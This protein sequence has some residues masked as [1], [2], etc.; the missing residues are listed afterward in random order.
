MVGSFD[1]NLRLYSEKGQELYAEGE[2]KGKSL[3]TMKIMPNFL[4]SEENFSHIVYSGHSDE[5]IRVSFFD[6][7]AKKTH[8]KPKNL[9]ITTKILCKGHNSSIE[10]LDTHPLENARFA[11][12]SY[13]GEL[14]LWH[15]KDLNS[16]TENE[17]IPIENTRKKLKI[18]PIKELKP[19]FRTKLHNDNISKILWEKP[20]SL[21]TGSFDHSIKVFDIE[22]TS[23]K[24]TFQCRDAAVTSLY[25]LNNKL[26]VSGHEDGYIKLWDFN[27]KSAKKIMKS[28]SLWVADIKGVEGNDM[29]FASAGYDKSVKIWDIR[30]EFPVFSLKSHS[31]KVFCL[32]WNGLLLIL[33]N[34][35]E[36]LLKFLKFYLFFILLIR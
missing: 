7:S 30:S 6:F 3:K 5:G 29:V 32:Q 27:E 11:S 14:A 22:K 21:I 8:K 31:D 13:E 1:G 35:I 23:E 36:I 24:A 10:T 25:G 33:L 19:L 26:F 16:L 17:G 28:H 12:G 2:I 18:S 34:F 4:I 15:I 20:E 9:D